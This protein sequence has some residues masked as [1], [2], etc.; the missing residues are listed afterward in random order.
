MAVLLMFRK[1][2]LSLLFSFTFL[3]PFLAQACEFSDTIAALELQSS[4]NYNYYKTLRTLSKDENPA[5]VQYLSE[6]RQL[7]EVFSSRNIKNVTESINFHN[8]YEKYNAELFE[9]ETQR[10]ELIWA[11]FSSLFRQ[12]NQYLANHPEISPDTDPIF[13]KVISE[14]LG[15]VGRTAFFAF[16][17]L[18][19]VT[20][21]LA[22]SRFNH[23]IRVIHMD[24][25]VQFQ[26]SAHAMRHPQDAFAISICKSLIHHSKTENAKNQPY[27]TVMSHQFTE[28]YNRVFK[29]SLAQKREFFELAESVSLYKTLETLLKI[30]LSVRDDYEIPFGDSKHLP[31]QIQKTTRSRLKSF[32]LRKFAPRNKSNSEKASHVLNSAEIEKLIERLTSE[33]LKNLTDRHKE[34]RKQ[35]KANQKPAKVL[36]DDQQP[37][38]SNN[39][40]LSNAL[41]TSDLV[42]KLSE[43]ENECPSATPYLTPVAEDC[44]PVFDLQEWLRAETAKSK[45]SNAG[46]AAASCSK[47]NEPTLTDL[48]I[49]NPIRLT[50]SAART[51]LSGLKFNSFQIQNRD[52]IEF[53]NQV[54]G[55]LVKNKGNGSEV[56]YFLPNFQSDRNSKPFKV[57]RIDFSHNGKTPMNPVALWKFFGFALEESGLSSLEMELYP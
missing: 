52:F 4:A 26:Y 19:D 18:A 28:A 46:I 27:I 1:L 44:Y 50:K 10:L 31:D 39:Q 3:S 42:V 16:H 14:L 6:H 8:L 2:F 17:N 48:R 25:K 38:L 51:Y 9:N 30:N 37:S 12:L 56:K 7:A 33:F 35:K 34:A 47:S 57:F 55:G 22:V 53:L 54:G 13:Q 21:D 29:E 20:L 36:N 23:V 11:A 24:E 49:S 45:K 40:D 43:P 32:V 5:V 41:G 15:E